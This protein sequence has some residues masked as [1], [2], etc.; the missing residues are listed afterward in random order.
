MELEILTCKW[1]DTPTYFEYRPSLEV[2]LKKYL[3]NI[4][5]IGNQLV[6]PVKIQW[7]IPADQ[8]MFSFTLSSTNYNFKNK[9][10]W[11]VS[12]VFI[13]HKEQHAK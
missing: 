8:V 10:Y 12:V 13:C 7:A 11:G 3:Q 1:H 5:K 9:F 4:K 6:Y 2:L